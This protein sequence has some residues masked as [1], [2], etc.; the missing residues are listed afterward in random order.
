MS[1]SNRQEGRSY[2]TLLIIA[3]AAALLFLSNIATNLIATDLDLTLRPFRP[4]VYGI[5]VVAFLVTVA[6]AIHQKRRDDAARASGGA[7]VAPPAAPAEEKQREVVVYRARDK[8]SALHQLPPPPR[9]FT[10]REQELDELRAGIERGG[11]TISGLHGF[12]GIGKT[13]LALKLAEELKPRYPDAQFYLDLK[14]VS[15]KP[16]TVAEALSHVVRAYHPTAKLPEAEADLRALYFSVLNDQRALLLMDNAAGREQVEPLIPPGGC[17]LLVTSRQRFALPGLFAKDLDTLPPADARRLL[18]TIAPRIGEQAEELARICGH[19]PLALRLAASA[20]A[21]RANLSAADYL[22]RLSD[23]RKRLE[24]VEASLGLSYDLLDPAL[25]KFWCAL[26]V[27]PD[28][29]DTAAAAAVWGVNADAAQDTLGELLR[30]SLVDW[31]EET[32]RHRLHDL[33]RLFASAHLAAAEREALHRRHATHYLHVLSEAD[34]LYLQSGEATRRGLALFDSEWRN[35]QAGQAWAAG[36]P[37]DDTLCSSYPDVGA[38]FLLLRLRPRERIAWFEAALDAARRLGERDTEGSHMANLGVA[39]AAMGEVSRAVEFFKQ[40]LDVSRE[41]GNRRGEADVLG[42]L[43]DVQSYMGE[44]RRAIESYKEQLRI[45]REIANRRG[46][47]NALGSL[48]NAWKN[49]GEPQRAIEFYE[50]ASA[51]FDEIGDLWAQEQTLINI[52][53]ALDDLGETR[54]AIEFNERAVAR[55][56]EI[57]DQMG[58]AIALYN[59]AVALSKLG[60]RARAVSSA[61]AALEIYE[62]MESRYA[63]RTRALLT[64][65]R[66]QV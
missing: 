53:A 35:I 44:P 54:R 32:G 43:G 24:L 26:A 17:V 63:E 48:G 20:L 30:Y 25:Q 65:L 2:F 22:R 21:E 4:W 57:G 37:G 31:R 61:E 29:F 42:S 16:L 36:Q 56:T 1:G 8:A 9:D 23:A 33:A 66:G 60:E 64:K 45:N 40:A 18:L 52:G 41:T 15:P 5:C 3:G 13:T 59:S 39:Y 49:L 11:A 28:T 46:E 58:R 27:F 55:A 50:Q 19:L 12:G 10:G 34:D 7:A 47:G 38:Y 14:G 62:Q 51:V 6:L